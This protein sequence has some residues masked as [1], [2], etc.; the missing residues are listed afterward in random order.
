MRDVLD[1]VG[2]V[3]SVIV[4]RKT[5]RLVDGHLRVQLAVDAGEFGGVCLSPDCAS[6]DPERDADRFFA[7]GDRHREL[8]RKEER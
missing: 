3:Q 8:R 5:G 1:R 7:G 6:Y 2:W 4:N